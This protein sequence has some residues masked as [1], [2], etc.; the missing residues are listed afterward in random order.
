MVWVFASNLAGR[1]GKGAARDALLHHGAIFGLGVGRGGN[2]YAIPTKDGDLG[3]LPLG[4]IRGHVGSFLAYA[5]AHPEL[6]FEVTQIGCGLAGY[7]P[8]QIAP[9]FET[10][11]SNCAFDSAWK[12]WLPGKRF[13]GTY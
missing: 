10:A 13:W 2:S 5:A 7:V 8:A 11:P 12:P 9:M 3:V 4:V 1:H 6:E